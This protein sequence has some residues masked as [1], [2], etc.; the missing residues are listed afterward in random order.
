V[1]DTWRAGRGCVPGHHESAGKR[2]SGRRRKGNAWLRAALIE[3]GQ[4]VGRT[5]R[6]YLGAQDRRLAG[7]R[8][9][10]RAAVAVGHSIL[11]I[12]YGITY[13]LLQRETTDADLGVAYFDERDRRAVER[14][15]IRRL[16]ALGYTVL[17]APAVA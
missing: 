17:L 8:G 3:A 13:H 2:R 16:E 5:K 11:G 10:K 4:A 12:T 9:A 6:T 14:R 7:R 15:L 1:P